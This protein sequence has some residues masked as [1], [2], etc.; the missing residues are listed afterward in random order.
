M[1]APVRR[2]VSA[3]RSRVLDINTLMVI[4]VAGALV[5]RDWLEAAS[6]VLLFALAQWLE[7]RTLDRAR[8]AIRALIDLSP[9][10]AIVRRAGHE[11]RTPVNEIRI[12][13]EIVIR[14]QGAA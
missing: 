4:A 8:Q 12:G 7:V 1:R 10:D 5:L 14:R 13:E 3:I 9:R 11:R 2:A 6:V